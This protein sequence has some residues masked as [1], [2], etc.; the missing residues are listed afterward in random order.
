MC[1]VSVKLY[2][3]SILLASGHRSARGVCTMSVKLYIMS[4]LLATGLDL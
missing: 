2:I 4:I 3:M 1:T